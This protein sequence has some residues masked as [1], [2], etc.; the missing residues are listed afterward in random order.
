MDFRSNIG[1]LY[2]VSAPSGAGKTTLCHELAEVMPNIAHAVSHTS[3]KPRGGETDGVHYYF[4]SE[5]E[6]R[7][8]ADEGGFAEW[9]HV[10]GNYYGTSK[11]ELDR[12]FGL[13]RDVIL[14]IDTQGADQL[15]KSGMDGTFIF[16]L[17]PDM[18]TLE[19]RLRGRGTD[20]DEVI[21]T[22]LRNAIGELDRFGDYEYV[23]VNDDL[24][25]AL[26]ALKAVVLSIKQKVANMDAGAIRSAF[27]LSK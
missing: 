12:L 19:G 20:S 27:G 1:Q 4:V 17:P 2:V 9:A 23:I 3:R 13:G 11:A 22:R 15:R 16:V 24:A 18:R 25:E 21:A 7:K 6:F 8:A 26:E 14:D 5:G 10:H